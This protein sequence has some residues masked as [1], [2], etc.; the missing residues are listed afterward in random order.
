MNKKAKRTILILACITVLLVVF[1]AVS[2]REGSS[3]HSVYK[4]IGT[5]FRYIQKGFSSFGRN[6]RSAFSVMGDYK[7]IENR[8]EE[9]QNEIKAMKS[10]E[11]I[12][13]AI[14]K[15]RTKS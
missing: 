13:S 1:I 14:L 4:V 3:L 10:N 6:I 2:S 8:I 5:P 7:E 9:L 12:R 15:M 11:I